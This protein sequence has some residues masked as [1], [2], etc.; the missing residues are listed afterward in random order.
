MPC[1]SAIPLLPYLS[2]LSRGHAPPPIRQPYLEPESIVCVCAVTLP[3]RLRWRLAF[4]HGLC[5]AVLGVFVRALLT[6]LCRRARRLGTRDGLGGAVT[7]VQ[8]FSHRQPTSDTR[9]HV[10]FARLW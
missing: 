5:R 10:N 8:R 4:D 9:A 1:H 3:Y 2:S 7:V 6:T